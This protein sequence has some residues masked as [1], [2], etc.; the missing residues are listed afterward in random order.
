M[1]I[2]SG[3]IFGLLNK[4]IVISCNFSLPT[5][6]SS[7]NKKNSQATSAAHGA[8]EQAWEHEAVSFEIEDTCGTMALLL[9]AAGAI[10]GP[11][12]PGC[13]VEPRL[14]AE[15]PSTRAGPGRWTTVLRLDAG[16][17]LGHSRV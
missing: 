12:G 8:G 17:I 5:S 15:A 13:E 7:S 10:S 2:F 1:S 6:F 3:S 11:C 14:P 16:Y 4:L 9:W